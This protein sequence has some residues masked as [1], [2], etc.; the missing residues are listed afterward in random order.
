MTN[1]LDVATTKTRTAS[2]QVMAFQLAHMLL[3]QI[4][5]ERPEG[6][7]QMTVRAAGGQVLTLE[8]TDSVVFT[9]TTTERER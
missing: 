2:T 3:D 1:Q 6:I 5:V 4:G 8:R 7:L 9:W